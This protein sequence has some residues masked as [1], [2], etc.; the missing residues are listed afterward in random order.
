MKKENLQELSTA[1]LQAKL[2]TL[3][4]GLIIISSL[5]ILYAV[6]FIYKLATGTW[7]A[8]TTLGTVMLG[9]LVI[10]ISTT[11]VRYMGIA[12]ILQQRKEEK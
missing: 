5:V 4:A 3:K 7:Q 1:E 11:M 10:V 9:M 12:K 8:N 6:F 2:K